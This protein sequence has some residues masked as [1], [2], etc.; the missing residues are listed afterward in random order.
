MEIQLGKRGTTNVAGAYCEDPDHDLII[1]K[2]SNNISNAKD[3][4]RQQPDAVSRL[5]GLGDS[6][7]SRIS[8]LG[9]RQVRVNSVEA[10]ENFELGL[11]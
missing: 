3:D 8:G 2:P 5:M 6:A 7:L 11:S 10:R 9:V 1:A 4:P